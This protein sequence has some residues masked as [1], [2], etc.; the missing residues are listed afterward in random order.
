MVNC[1]CTSLSQGLGY[2]RGSQL[3]GIT[4]SSG[5]A[6]GVG[7]AVDGVKHQ[8]AGAEEQ[9]A[10]RARRA[11]VVR[12]IRHAAAAFQIHDIRADAHYPFW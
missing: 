8:Q 2:V 10:G 6:G 12:C 7:A 1:L 4:F 9:P 5:H 11:Q 3:T